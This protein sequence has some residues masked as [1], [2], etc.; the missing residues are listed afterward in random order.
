MIWIIIPIIIAIIVFACAWYSENFGFGLIAGLLSGAVTFLLCAC[1]ATLALDIVID[2]DYYK[3][4]NWEVVSETELIPIAGTQEETA[5]Y[6]IRTVDVDSDDITI[7]YAVQD[8]DTLRY[9]IK[10]MD[11]NTSEI[12]VFYHDTVTPAL[13][14][15]VAKVDNFWLKFFAFNEY[16]R[17][18]FVVPNGSVTQIA[19]E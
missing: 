9:E 7:T 6:L 19:V 12:K 3:N 2:S 4:L 17:Y 14:T 8:P 11:S 16:E 15:E 13:V 10:D 1:M 5:P 18:S